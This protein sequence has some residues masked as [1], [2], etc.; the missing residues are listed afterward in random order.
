MAALRKQNEARMS[1][2]LDRARIM[3]VSIVEPPSVPELPTTST[4]TKFLVGL[5]L[6]LCAAIGMVFMAEYFDPSFRTPQEVENTL[7]LPVLT[8]IPK[9]LHGTTYVIELPEEMAG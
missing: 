9:A 1:A 6:S 2:A 5:M 3:N 8:T 7:S 4:L